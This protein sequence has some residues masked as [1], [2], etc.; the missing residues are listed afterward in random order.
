MGFWSFLI[1]VVLILGG[2]WFCRRLLEVE[3]D[4]RREMD[5]EKNSVEDT[6]EETEE[7]PIPQQPV[8]Q[9]SA[10][11]ELSGIESLITRHVSEFPGLLQPELYKKI[12]DVRPKAL[13]AVLRKMD[14]KGLVRREKEQGSYRLYIA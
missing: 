5:A 1:L 2:A 9:E 6:L 8:Q 13:Q 3:K 12:P 10:G 14:Q 7:A 11:Q 4:I